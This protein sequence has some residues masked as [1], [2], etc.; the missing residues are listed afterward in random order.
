ME[1]PE[2]KEI[3]HAAKQ[4]IEGAYQMGMSGILINK[5]LRESNYAC[6]MITIHETLWS[7][8]IFPDNYNCSSA[9]LIWRR[10]LTNILETFNLS[11]LE[12]FQI[13][14]LQDAIDYYNID[15]DI[16]TRYWNDF[17]EFQN[18]FLQE[19]ENPPNVQWIMRG[20]LY[21]GFTFTGLAKKLNTK[22][23]AISTNDMYNIYRQ[24]TQTYNFS[25]EEFKLRP[26]YHATEDL[27]TFWKLSYRIGKDFD[28]ISE[29][30]EIFGGLGIS[31]ENKSYVVNQIYEPI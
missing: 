27:K 19:I 2:L 13:V 5:F 7:V 3:D 28:T 18:Q 4:F 26:K 22:N 30:T 17:T 21:F 1:Y 25:A 10:F 29:W 23:I 6:N 12:Q 20:L 24:V 15:N 11:T 16:F 14:A 9:S 8:N 31:E